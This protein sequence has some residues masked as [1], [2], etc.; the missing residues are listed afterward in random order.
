M[1]TA[2]GL[3]APDDSPSAGRAT[4]ARATRTRGS[5]LVAA[6]ALF[7]ANGFEATRLEDVASAVGIR[8]ASIVYYFKDKA[9]LYH[10]VLAD[11][12]AQLEA[13]IAAG[14]GAS[15]PSKGELGA[16]PSSVTERIENGV[17]AWIDF[18]EARP[19]FARIL[20]RE[21]AAAQP[22][23]PPS[24]LAA[25]LRGIE[26]VARAMLGEL[27][28]SGSNFPNAIDPAHFATAIAGASV[29]YAA[30]MP[31]LTSGSAS[32]GRLASHEQHKAEVIRTAHRL[33]GEFVS[34][35]PEGSK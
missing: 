29:F 16:A 12:A 23:G 26:S 4:T 20:L 32:A 35:K 13:A 17:G 1:V 11:I 9:A 34:P 2:P 21:L 15:P 30:A 33:L 6:E 31:S 3:S 24:P 19:A 18:L 5:I 22:D 10:A 27:Q 8:R 7:A 14:L 28:A 25:H